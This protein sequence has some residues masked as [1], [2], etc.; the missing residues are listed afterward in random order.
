M[1]ESLIA[2]ILELRYYYIIHKFDE[3]YKIPSDIYSS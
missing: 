2:F 1:F 3:E